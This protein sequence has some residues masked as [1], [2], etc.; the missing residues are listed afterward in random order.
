M[1]TLKP[2]KPKKLLKSIE[3][4]DND[5]YSLSLN[6]GLATIDSTINIIG[7]EL[8]VSGKFSFSSKLPDGWIAEA[9]AK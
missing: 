7:I 6:Y 8:D 2:R 5:S 4:N 1:I 9:G 3:Q